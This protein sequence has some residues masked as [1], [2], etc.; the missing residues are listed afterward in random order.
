M[1]KVAIIAA[2]AYF[3][4]LCEFALYNT[5]GPWGKPELLILLFVFFNLYMG[6]RYSIIAAVV[7]GL[8]KDSLGISPF[9]TYLFVYVAGAY[10]TTF[11]SK[12]IY[13]PGSRFSRAIVAFFV[14]LGCFVLEIALHRMEHDIH[15]GEAFTYVIWPQLVTTMV[16]ATFV[17]H[18][19]RDVSVLCHLKD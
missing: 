5:F 19:L 18:R 16:L 1:K 11:V 15:F 12:Y 2:L 9:G 3:L 17:F 4:V 10:W 7:C 14:V 6:I 8:L 13:Q